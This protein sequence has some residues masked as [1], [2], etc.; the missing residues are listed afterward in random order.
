MKG[1]TF[2]SK[3]GRPG[4]IIAG[5][6]NNNSLE[7]GLLPIGAPKDGEAEIAAYRKYGSTGWA[8]VAG[9]MGVLAFIAVLVVAGVG[10]W[11]LQV[12]QEDIS[13]LDE[14]L[15]TAEE[16]LVKHTEQI[17]ALNETLIATDAQVADNT[18]RIVTLNA[19]QISQGLRI[20]SLENRTTHLEERLTE[21]EIIL[22]GVIANVTVLQQTLQIA[23]LNITILQSEVAVLQGNVS[24]HG[25]RLAALE[26]EYAAQQAQ[27][28]SILAMITIID[29]RLNELNITYTVTGSGRAT[30]ESGVAL[31][32]PVTWQTRHYSYA[33]LDFEYLWIST[34]N[35]NP[36]QIRLA[37]A[38]TYSF[39]VA[40]FTTT[41][42][43]AKLPSPSTFLQRPLGP[44]QQSKF[45][46]QSFVPHPMVTASAWDNVNGVL[47]F[48]SNLELF[49][50][51]TI[52]APLTFVVG[53]L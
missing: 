32:S 47:N 33:G 17:N 51:V 19:T 24:N 40:N 23:I 37:N 39:Q 25:M 43:F 14:R 5:N 49:D 22:L 1:A 34:T 12:Q 7:E 20:T 46:L 2:R 31:T 36:T 41:P 28:N 42:P 26:A 29:D 6:T 50:A 13:N 53:F 44:F 38:S 4:L 3:G 45:L 15:T 9:V 48:Y 10:L 8:V 27:I 16:L 52:V 18:R 11:R 35:G 30:V 21:D